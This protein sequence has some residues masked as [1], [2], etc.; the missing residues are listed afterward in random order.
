[1]K[2]AFDVAGEGPDVVIAHGLFGSKSNWRS[3]VRKLEDRFRIFTVDLRNH[4]E[5]PHAS[6]MGY[7]D[8][9]DDLKIFIDDHCSGRAGVVGHSMGGKAMMALALRSPQSVERLA[10]VDV[11]PVAYEL[12]GV[13]SG[14]INAMLDLDLS[15]VDSRSDADQQ[16]AESISEP[17][18]RA[19]LLQN[20]RL[21]DGSWQWRI[22]LSALKESL[23]TVRNFAFE[24]RYDGPTLFLRGADSDYFTDAMEPLAKSLFPNM[25]LETIDGSGHWVH[26]QK[27]DAVADTLRGFLCEE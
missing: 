27:P 8:M 5:S 7:E 3:I 9:A 15:A 11:A 18:I 22:N 21:E 16:L 19:F 14:F 2:L 25:R 23:Q 26:A 10:V 12:S 24:G 6:A 1:M 4:G 17:P 20:L 13:F